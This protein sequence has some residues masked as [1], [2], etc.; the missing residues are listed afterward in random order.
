MYQC[1]M[2]KFNRKF[3]NSCARFSFWDALTRHF[4]EFEVLIKP[5]DI[6]TAEDRIAMKKI[7][8]LLYQG[9]QAS[10]DRKAFHL[11]KMDCLKNE[12]R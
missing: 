8:N 4:A 5:Q 9:Y 1:N 12:R 6:L 7:H 10:K 3:N 2:S 11:E